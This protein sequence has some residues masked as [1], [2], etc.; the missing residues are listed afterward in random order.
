ML[1]RS[2]ADHAQTERPRPNSNEIT[3]RG[4]G[5]LILAVEDDEVVRSQAVIMLSDIGYD[6]VEAENARFA[7]ELLGA[8]SDIRVMFTDVAMPGELNGFELAEL[9]MRQWP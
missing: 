5:E 3:P 6:V 1:P 7:L 2:Q 9:A 8:R 4:N